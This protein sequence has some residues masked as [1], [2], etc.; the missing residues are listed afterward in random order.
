MEEQEFSRSGVKIIS[1]LM[2]MLASQSFK[3]S[4]SLGNE[5]VFY[6]EVV[7][8]LHQI[9]QQKKNITALIVRSRFGFC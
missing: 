7:Q 1:A 2:C 8:F 3:Y 5:N 4:F 6:F 9:Q